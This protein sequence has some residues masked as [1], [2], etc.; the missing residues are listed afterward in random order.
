M[1]YWNN[2]RI[3]VYVIPYTLFELNEF[4]H[5]TA[6]E[7][8]FSSIHQ[9]WIVV[10]M[11]S[12]KWYLIK[13]LSFVAILR[14]I[15]FCHLFHLK[16]TFILIYAY[17]NF[18]SISLFLRWILGICS[19]C[20]AFTWMFATNFILTDIIWQQ[21]YINL[22]RSFSNEKNAVNNKQFYQN[23]WRMFSRGY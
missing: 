14:N 18:F 4:K 21:R 23:F 6:D 15:R 7:V 22:C 9:C 11:V 1:K 13:L 5:V 2:F 8:L 16:I 3:A 10:A 19:L 12:S 20:S 17:D